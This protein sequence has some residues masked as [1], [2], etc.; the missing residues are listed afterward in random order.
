MRAAGRI[1][2]C[3]VYAIAAVPVLVL[4]AAVRRYAVNVPYWDEWAVATLFP[5]FHAGHLRLADL[6]AQHNESRLFFPR[7]VIL[8]LG[9]LGHGDVRAGMFATI[10]LACVV[11]GC[12]WVLARR[13][14][15]GSPLS[16]A[17][18][19]AIS[20]V[21]IFG[22]VQHENWL[23]GMQLVALFPL[24]CLSLGLVVATSGRPLAS[25]F[26]AAMALATVSS[27]SFSNGSLSWVL[28]LP[29]VWVCSPVGDAPERA[30]R[31]RWTA[32]Y[33]AGFVLSLALYFAGYRKPA[34][35]P[36]LGEALHEPVVASAYLLSFLGHPLAAPW[37]PRLS[38][39]IAAGVA[40]LVVSA[41]TAAAFA[42]LRRQRDLLPRAAPWLALAGYAVASALITTVG[43]VGFG[44]DQSLESRY[45]AF[46]T[47]LPLALLHLTAIACVSAAH[48]SRAGFARAAR[49][50]AVAVTVWF[51]VASVWTSV[52]SIP[53]MAET[54]ARRLQASA[55]LQWSAVVER[56][57]QIA[58]TLTPDVD[59]MLRVAARFDRLDYLSP[60]RIVDPHLDLV[61]E[62]PG[63]PEEDG[64]LDQ[65][66][67][68]PDGSV[69]ATGWAVLHDAHRLAD[70]VLL[71][72]DD[73][74]G[75]PV[76][77]D[78]TVERVPRSDV[79]AHEG[80]SGYELS[81]FEIE[82]PADAMKGV[83]A[84]TIRAWAF[85]AVERRAYPLVRNPPPVETQ[86][87]EV[88]DAD[89]AAVEP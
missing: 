43:R 77:F 68:E 13:T 34:A 69:A 21:L 75:R 49:A 82:V 78:L 39:A 65:V 61:A 50:L 73:E 2:A 57:H 24:V 89:P 55:V 26:A 12:V 84:R 1:A 45:S 44:L 19:W 40:L 71:S 53:D 9:G 64:F 29:V 4:I 8:A 72:H 59:L 80:W 66:R 41:L 51:G 25:R 76:A 14:V 27:F 60:P 36:P 48:E 22:L 10:G 86:P 6:W 28:L 83:D 35:H 33:A 58:L 17:A 37:L 67:E 20:N 87:A 11:S 54:R 15:G 18:L 42:R 46:A 23:M 81:G 16:R 47:Y 56:P 85:D 70:A 52:A 74:S 63:S 88:P 31:A 5:R 79:A 62:S 30:R 38:S 32:G 7:I 3:F